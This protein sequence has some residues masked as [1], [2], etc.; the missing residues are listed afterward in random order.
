MV[1]NLKPRTLALGRVETI[2]E[3]S[4]ILSVDIGKGELVVQD[5]DGETRTV[6]VRD[7]FFMRSIPQPG[8]YLIR[9]TDGHISHCSRRRAVIANANITA[10]KAAAPTALSA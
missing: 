3:V 7:S 1:Q 5:G 4:E 9:Y 8:N 10:P 2:A 6:V